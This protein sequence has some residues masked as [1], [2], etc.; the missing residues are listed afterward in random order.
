LADPILKFP[1]D[2]KGNPPA[3]PFRGRSKAGAVV[4]LGFHQRF[5]GVPAGG[6][7]ALALAGGLIFYLNGAAT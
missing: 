4:P 3:L 1:P 2:Q 5:A 7:A 6:A